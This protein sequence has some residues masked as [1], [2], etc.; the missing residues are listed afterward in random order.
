[1]RSTIKATLALALCLMALASGCSQLARAQDEEHQFA[2]VFASA[3]GPRPTFEETQRDLQRL[4]DMVS[5][6]EIPDDVQDKQQLE[7]T[8]ERLGRLLEIS[9]FSKAKCDRIFSDIQL[10]KSELSDEW[11]NL[12]PYVESCVEQQQ[13]YCSQK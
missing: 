6:L 10:V 1:M 11:F 8:R 4:W 2:G 13:V 9:E 12:V 7:E 3:N 5:N